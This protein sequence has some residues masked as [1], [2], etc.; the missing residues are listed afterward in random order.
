MALI[1]MESPKNQVTTSPDLAECVA[2]LE[3]IDEA[4][5]ELGSETL[6]K[7]LMQLCHTAI[8]KLCACY[9][10]DGR[11]AL[12]SLMVSNVFISKNAPHGHLIPTAP[13]ELFWTTVGM[14]CF[15][16]SMNFHEG[17]VCLS[18]MMPV[19]GI[20]DFKRERKYYKHVQ[21]HVLAA[22]KWKLVFPT[23]WKN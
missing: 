17:S 7:D 19:V 13:F 10:V 4:R 5:T 14:V 1:I 6:Y 22:I 15:T 2:G 20:C 23:G 11:I 8:L 12:H 3:Y 18:D 21:M 16:L 9:E